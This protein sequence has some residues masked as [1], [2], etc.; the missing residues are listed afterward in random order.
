[1]LE[2]HFFVLIVYYYVYKALKSGIH[3]LL[4][5]IDHFN[6]STYCNFFIVN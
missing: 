1:M 3:H 4:K 6:L 5:K 2:F